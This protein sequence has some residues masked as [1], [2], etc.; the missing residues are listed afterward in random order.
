MSYPP[1]YRMPEHPPM[2]STRLNYQHRPVGPSPYIAETMPIDMNTP[3]APPNNNPCKC[4]KALLCILLAIASIF[5][6][7][8]LFIEL[9]NLSCKPQ[10]NMDDIQSLL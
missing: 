4:L 1:P 7:I 9:G 8:V 3:T 10:S 2:S 6:T 5:F